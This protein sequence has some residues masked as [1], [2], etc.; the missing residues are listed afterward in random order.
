MGVTFDD[1]L[2][3]ERGYAP[4]LV[5][6]RQQPGTAILFQESHEMLIEAID[7]DLELL[8]IYNKKPIKQF[9]IGKSYACV[10]KRFDFDPCNFKTWRLNGGVNG[11]WG[12]YKK[13]KYYD[14]LV[15][16]CAVTRDMIAK[17]KEATARNL[18]QRNPLF[19]Q[20]NY[21]IALEQHLIHHYAYVRWDPRL[22][23]NTLHIGRQS[24]EY[25]AGVVYV[26]YKF[27]PPQLYIHVI[28][29]LRYYCVTC[30]Q[31]QNFC[32]DCGVPLGCSNQQCRK[33]AR[34]RDIYCSNC[35]RDRCSVCSY[36]LCPSHNCHQPY[37]CPQCKGPYC[38][39]CDPQ[40]LRRSS[41]IQP[42]NNLSSTSYRA[43]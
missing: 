5:Q 9:T 29:Q 34:S 15:V 31:S 3:G 42:S 41:N 18:P 27:G 1:L 35:H 23:N 7:S 24:A 37:W 39:Q 33:R 10:H 28:S 13:D 8:Q 30:R 40:S 4:R 17:Q 43:S 25:K 22:E 32:V 6:L 14:G 2:R 11:R 21:A 26:A 20:Q 36:Q 16:L 38:N 12:E 19:S